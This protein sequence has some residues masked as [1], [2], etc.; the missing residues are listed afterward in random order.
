MSDSNAQVDGI[1]LLPLY[2]LYQWGLYNAGTT[3]GI[4]IDIAR[5]VVMSGVAVVA[6]YMA[7]PNDDNS[8]PNPENPF[9]N[10]IR[11]PTISDQVVVVNMF[12]N[13]PTAIKTVSNNTTYNIGQAGTA[14]LVDLTPIDALHPQLV[15]ISG[16]I[17]T[18]EAQTGVLPVDR[19]GYWLRNPAQ[20]IEPNIGT[21]FWAYR[22]EA[23][24][25]VARGY[26]T[27][28]S[29]GARLVPSP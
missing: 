1:A 19:G 13:M 27:W 26:A 7:G 25:L 2:F 15:I 8:D 14:M 29:G 16:G 22:A 21:R 17:Y 12:Q 23:L 4:P 18:P 28:P 10:F 24:A 5:E 3:A 9:G 20:V 6:G 11:P